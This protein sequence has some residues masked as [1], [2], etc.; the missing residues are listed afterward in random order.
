MSLT[1]TF[2]SCSINGWKADLISG[3]RN[4][5]LVDTV[6]GTA[7][8]IS[9]GFSTG[10]SGDGTQLITGAPFYP[11]NS[12]NGAV[13]FTAI[14]NNTFFGNTLPNDVGTT[15]IDLGW[16]VDINYNSTW[17]VAGAPTGPTGPGEIRIYQSTSPNVWTLH[18]QTTGSNVVTNERFGVEVA[19][20]GN[21]NVI[22]A[23]E[24]RGDA[25][26]VANSGSVYIYSFSSNVW[27]EITELT[28]NDASNLQS[29]GEALSFNQSGNVLAIGAYGDD[30]LGTD[31]GAAYIFTA[32]GNVWTQQAKLTASDGA[33][34]DEFGRS[35][36]ITPNASHVVVG[37]IG[38]G[39]GAAYVFANVANTWVQQTKI[40][41][42]QT[43]A[44][45]T[46]FGYGVA[47]SA[48]ATIVAI[49]TS[50]AVV[51]SNNA[52]YIFTGN[53]SDYIQTQEIVN[54]AGNTQGFG[55][56][57]SMSYDGSKIVVSDPG[58]TGSQGIV[59]LYAAL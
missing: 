58:Y 50:S 14:S 19:I 22:A 20:A 5:Q 12:Q 26:N 21:A 25:P 31:A 32:S 51:G 59:Y 52:M 49:T 9:F 43:L 28:A 57:I 24:S 10:I 33:A 54:P 1:T 7:N 3:V 40:E 23:T 46:G 39:N 2:T 35:I 45:N 11:N 53:G 15:G 16:D 47:I 55:D 38:A 29:F 34:G 13:Y 41:P 4:Y 30:G 27:N 56:Y 37:A 48:D 8:I 17:A 36:A 42:I 18:T 44:N 6:Q